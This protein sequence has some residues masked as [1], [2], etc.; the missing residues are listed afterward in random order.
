MCV[1]YSKNVYV[2]L[3]IDAKHEALV[4]ADTVSWADGAHTHTHRGKDARGRAERSIHTHT[5]ID[6]RRLLRG[7]RVAAAAV[8]TAVAAVSAT[9]THTHIHCK[10]AFARFSLVHAL[11]AQYTLYVPYVQS[12][13]LPL[14]CYI[15]AAAAAAAIFTH[16]RS[17]LHKHT[18]LQLF[19]TKSSLIF[20]IHFYK[21]L[22]DCFSRI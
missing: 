7:N 4:R 17:V 8:R 10:N 13:L 9:H 1:F 20:T 2:L 11:S 14:Y 5:Y 12:L 21:D 6:R 18:W 22:I 15:A 16:I 3:H 19:G